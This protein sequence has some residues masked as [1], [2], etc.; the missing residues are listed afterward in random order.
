MI[1]SNLICLI[2]IAIL[3]TA[4]M[5]N[6]QYFSSVQTSYARNGKRSYLEK[7]VKPMSNDATAGAAAS[8]SD[9]D[10]SLKAS[11]TSDDSSKSAA[12]RL[13]KNNEPEQGGISRS[14]YFKIS[15]R[16]IDKYYMA[17]RLSFRKSFNKF[18]KR[19]NADDYELDDDDLIDIMDRNNRYMRELLA[20]RLY[21]QQQFRSAANNAAKR[22][23]DNNNDDSAATD[24][25]ELDL[26]TLP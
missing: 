11:S 5:A 18:G 7:L 9:E 19:G 8:V 17:D 20:R 16:P 14:K 12:R 10:E 22:G 4:Y 24:D 2:V 26:I 15:N 1:K 6:G 13:F 25:Y 3:A 23:G 21:R